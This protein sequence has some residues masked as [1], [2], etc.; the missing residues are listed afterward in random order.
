VWTMTCVQAGVMYQPYSTAQPLPTSPYLPPSTTSTS[1]ISYLSPPPLL[2][3]SASSPPSHPHYQE[4]ALPLKRELV[5]TPFKERDMVA[6]SDRLGADSRMSG[7]EGP[8]S[9]PRTANGSSAGS[10]GTPAP[11]TPASPRPGSQPGSDGEEEEGVSRCAQYLARNVV[12]YTHYSGEAANIVDEHFTKALNQTTFSELKGTPMASRN[13]P[14]SFFNAHYH[15]KLAVGYSDAKLPYSHPEASG[16]YSEAYTQ[17]LHHLAAHASSPD[18]WQYAAQATATSSYHR[19][20]QDLVNSAGSY[21]SS[22]AS[23]LQSQY[24]LFLNS[25]SSRLHSG[26]IKAEPGNPW[27]G[28]DYPGGPGHPNPGTDFP[29]GSVPPHPLERNYSPHPGYPNMPSTG[30][31]SAGQE[32]PKDLYWPTF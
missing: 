7:Q 4:Q 32:P 23:R 11:R 5:D 27:G 12:L 9:S 8:Y 28:S 26:Q 30:L 20:V 25:P 21:S 3:S 14:P 1:S 2:A 10:C 31:E 22:P 17:G 29:T 15:A 24:S 19:S 6:A 18:P 13:L 16:L